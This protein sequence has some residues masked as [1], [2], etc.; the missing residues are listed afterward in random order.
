MNTMPVN[1]YILVS[2]VETTSAPERRTAGLILQGESKPTTRLFKSVL[3]SV[4]EGQPIHEGATLIV[5]GDAV[6]L[7]AAVGD[8]NLTFIHSRD[9]IGVVN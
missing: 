1:G 6:P 9:T 2:P 3:A 4:I 7:T 5:R 8:Q